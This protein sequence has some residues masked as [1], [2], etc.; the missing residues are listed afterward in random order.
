[1]ISNL[2]SIFTTTTS[3][4]MREFRRQE[5]EEELNCIPGN[6]SI[7]N[8]HGLDWVEVWDGVNILSALFPLSCSY[9]TQQQNMIAFHSREI[10]WTQQNQKII[11]PRRKK[12]FRIT[13]AHMQFNPPIFS[14]KQRVIRTTEEKIEKD[15]DH[16]GFLW[17]ILLSSLSSTVYLLLHCHCVITRDQMTTRLGY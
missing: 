3:H 10:K 7:L 4:A 1:M 2:S 15:D 6:S 16:L 12:T 14:N 5:K 8:R 17:T 9:S 13:I 11:S